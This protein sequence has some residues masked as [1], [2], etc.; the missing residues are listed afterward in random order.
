VQLFVWN[1]SW[2]DVAKQHELDILCAYP[3]SNFPGGKDE[4]A[5]NTICAE[6]SP[7]HEI[8]PDLAS[9]QRL[10]VP[11]QIARMVDR[12]GYLIRTL[13]LNKSKLRLGIWRR[14]WDYNQRNL[15][16][17]RVGMSFF[18]TATYCIPRIYFEPSQ[19]LINN[20]VCLQPENPESTQKW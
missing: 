19:S 16:L 15:L 3:A 9:P 11:F 12:S 1:D 18:D 2:D 6:H 17:G 4:R 7:H 20:S 13:V 5:F 8:A 10:A 14:G